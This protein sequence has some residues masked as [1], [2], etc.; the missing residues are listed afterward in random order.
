MK[1][2]RAGWLAIL[3]P[4]LALA[5]CNRSAPPATPPSDATGQAPFEPAMQG[6]ELGIVALGDSLFAGYGLRPEQSYPVKLEQAL[7]ARGINARVTNAGV[8]GNTSGDGLQRLAFTLDNQPA[9]PRL[10]IISLGGND[11]LRGLPPAEARSN[12]DAILAELDKR[13][14]PVVVMGM[15]AAPNLGQQYAHAFNAI[16]PEVASKHHAVLVPF[17]LA[18]VVDKPDLVQPDHIHPAAAGVDVIVNATVDTVAK[19]LGK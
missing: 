9:P 3:A 7:R 4:V 14:I 5:G 11:M 1:F 15:L 12:L 16:Y 17:F 2:S 13:H 6:P 8:S 19:S 18:P 10:V